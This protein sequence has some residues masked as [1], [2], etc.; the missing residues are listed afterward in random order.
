MIK[1]NGNLIEQERFGDNT[2]KCALTGIGAKANS[3]IFGNLVSTD[4]DNMNTSEITWCYDSDDELFTLACIVDTL[5]DRDPL[6][7][8]ILT[9]PYIPNARQDR[10]VSGRLFT[11]KTFAK[12]INSMNFYQVKVIDPH[13]DVSTALIDRVKNMD[14]ITDYKLKKMAVDYMNAHYSGMPQQIMYPDNGAAKKYNATDDNIV[15]VKHRNEEGRIDSY[16][17]FGIKDGTKSVLIIDDICGYGGT[18]VSASKELRKQG[19]ENVYLCVSHCENNILKGGVFDYI[20]G[21]FT[22]DSICTVEHPKL[23]V[24]KCWR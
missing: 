23:H 20:G 16:S 7:Q 1:V 4:I 22:T 6:V 24:L 15:G 19:V 2:L 5:R 3:N 8:I 17:L 14:I 21:V 18:F 11:L 13:S 9:M 12:I 10:C